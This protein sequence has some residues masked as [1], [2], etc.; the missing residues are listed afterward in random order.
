MS[1]IYRCDFC[2]DSG[3]ASTVHPLEP[4]PY[5]EHGARVAAMLDR[6]P[7]VDPAPARPQSAQPAA[8]NAPAAPG[9]LSLSTTR[10]ASLLKAAFY[11][12][13]GLGVWVV[14]RSDEQSN[15]LEPEPGEPDGSDYSTWEPEE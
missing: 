15:T 7:S 6:Q 8:A 2:L 14:L 5:C 3:Y 10:T 13:V 1:S 4:C 9:E 12:G 11:V